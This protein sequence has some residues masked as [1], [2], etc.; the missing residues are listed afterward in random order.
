MCLLCRHDHEYSC[1][2]TNTDSKARLI[3]RGSEQVGSLR[4][5][6]RRQSRTGRDRATKCN[7]DM[8]FLDKEK[9]TE[10]PGDTRGH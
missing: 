10:K 3:S 9:G 2:G 1:V 4:L 7:T 5:Y 8:T 6:L